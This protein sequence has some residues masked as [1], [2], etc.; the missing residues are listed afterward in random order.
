M[1]DSNIYGSLNHTSITSILKLTDKFQ[2]KLSPEEDIL[3]GTYLIGAGKKFS[4]MFY[5]VFELLDL[6]SSFKS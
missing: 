1:R 6:L 3:F 4:V 5:V 2:S